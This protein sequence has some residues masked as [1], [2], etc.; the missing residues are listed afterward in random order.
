MSNFLQRESNNITVANFF[1]AYQLK[2]YN[3]DPDYQRKSI[4]S[5]EKKSFLIDS[6]IKNFPIPPIFLHQKI[7]NSSGA[8]KYDVIDGKQRLSAIIDF[9]ENK[10]SISD[11]EEGSSLSG[12][13]F[14]DLD[15][16]E[17][18]EYKKRIWRYT[19]SIEYIDTGDK[20]VIDSIFDRLNRN[21]EPLTGQ[22]LRNANYYQTPLLKSVGEAVKNDFWGLRLKVVDKSRME[23]IEFISELYFLISE[24]SELTASMSKTDELYA[25]YAVKTEADIAEINKKFV[26]ITNFL[27]DL[28]L[29]YMEYR[30]GGVSHLYGLFAFAKHCVD[31]GIEGDSISGDLRNFYRELRDQTFEDEN[32]KKYKESMS[33]RTKDA[34]S[35]R[36]RKAAL[37]NY[38]VNN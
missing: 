10:I 11:E 14:R 21:G 12:L 33:S 13:Y 22:E 35:R 37:I 16:P 32:I 28:N 23:D 30:F 26:E 3:F 36:K 27:S 31:E 17:Y 8:T 29:D 6:I 4:W 2:K 1:E 20:A 25:K 24:E 9:L 18:A 15:V 38:C 7:D 5:D 34:S 19:L